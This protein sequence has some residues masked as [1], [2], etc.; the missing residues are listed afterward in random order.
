MRNAFSKKDVSKLHVSK[1]KLQRQFFAANK[2]MSKVNEG[3]STSHIT[4]RKSS[5][6]SSQ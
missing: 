3:A 1:P 2:R 4:G 6:D 5:D